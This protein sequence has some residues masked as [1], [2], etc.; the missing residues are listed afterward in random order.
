MSQAQA[1]A[2]TGGRLSQFADR[3]FKYLAITPAVLIILGGYFVLRFFT[4]RTPQ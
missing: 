3:R 2:L 1:P 4:N